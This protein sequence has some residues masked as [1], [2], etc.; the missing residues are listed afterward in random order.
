MLRL[1]TTSSVAAIAPWHQV[2]RCIASHL[3]RDW[4]FRATSRVMPTA[5]DFF[6]RSVDWLRIGQT[7]STIELFVS[8]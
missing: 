5:F 6:V 4:N 2:A 7:C 3:I 8:P 1:A